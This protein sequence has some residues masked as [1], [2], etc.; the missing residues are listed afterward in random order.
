MAAQRQPMQFAPESQLQT[1]SRIAPGI[2][3]LRGVQQQQMET[4][5]A[6]RKQQAY[7]Q[8]QTEVAKAFPGGAK[9]MSRVLLTFGTSP[10]HLELGQKLMLVAEEQDERQRI[11]GGGAAAPMPDAMPAAMPAAAPEEVPEMD[12]GA[13]GGAQPVNA[14]MAQTAPAK[15]LEYAGRQYSPDQVGQMLQSRNAQLQQ[16]G[17]A[18]ADANKPQGGDKDE[19]RSRM[20]AMGLPETQEGF[21]QY[22]RITQPQ[23]GLSEQRFELE[24]QRAEM[25][26]LRFQASQAKSE[27]DARTA[28]RN[29]ALA[30]RRYELSVRQFELTSDPSYQA[31]LAAAKTTASETAKSDVAALSEAPVAIEQGQ[32]A[33]ALLNR[34]VGN[35][36]GKG[37]ETQPHPGF[38]GVVGAT[39]LPGARLVQG[40]PEADFDA[41]LEQVLGGAFLEAYERLKGTGQITEIEGK[42][43]TQAISRMG[44]AVSEAE[45]M[46]AAKEFR[47]A[48]ETAMERTSTRWDR[49]RTR[50]EPPVPQAGTRPPAAAAPASA[51]PAGPP[52]G[53]TFPQPTQAAID[54]LKRGQGTDAQF[55]AIFGPGA[56]AKARGR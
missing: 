10:E 15:M 19:V 37:A 23:L 22:F 8:F 21:A 3:A 26:R 51:A 38:Q 28:Q 42:K 12:F 44:R 29:L 54:A 34:M 47:S 25:D 20:R 39:L 6:V 16:L 32:R 40:T 53:R 36:K 52:A 7:Q 55:D 46:Q 1:L 2:N 18:I 49:A 14:M 24:K 27:A 5:E 31:R 56:A 11:F 35:P 50:T 43:A 17:R 9:E 4:A 13:A 48:L 30:E 41:M 45:F 33:L